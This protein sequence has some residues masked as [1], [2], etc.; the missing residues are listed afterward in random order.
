[1]KVAFKKKLPGISLSPEKA[2]VLTTW[3]LSFQALSENARHL[4]HM[5]AF[6]SNEDIPDKLFR[7]GKSAIHWI[8]E[9]GN[10]LDDAIQSLFSFSLAKRKESSGGFWIHPLVHAWAREHTHATVQWQNVLDTVALVGSAFSNRDEEDSWL[11]DLFKGRF[12]THLE[13]CGEH[14]SEYLSGTKSIE[15]VNVWLDIASAFTKLRRWKKAEDL[16]QK[17]LQ[18]KEKALG[19]DDPSVLEIMENIG[20]VSVS[21]NRCG[22]AQEWF[23]MLVARKEKAFGKDDPLVLKTIVDIALIFAQANLFDETQKWY[24]RLV[25][26]KDKALAKDHPSTPEIRQNI[27]MVVSCLGWYMNRAQE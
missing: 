20:L 11:V 9:D 4:L 7:R 5:C 14:I 8:E 26:R 19:K 17:A 23:N 13:L 15:V 22:E 1:M 24:E 16:Y 25:E 3:E 12:S 6:L 27:A 21:R 18:W 2:S 10:N